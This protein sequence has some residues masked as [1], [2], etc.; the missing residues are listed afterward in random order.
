MRKPLNS[1]LDAPVQSFVEFV[2]FGGSQPGDR[3]TV[4][5]TDKI[6]DSITGYDFARSDYRTFR[7]QLAAEI[8]TLNSEKAELNER[9]VNEFIRRY[10]DI[11]SKEELMEVVD[12]IATKMFRYFAI[13]GTHI[14]W[15]SPTP[16]MESE[17]T[18]GLTNMIFRRADCKEVRVQFRDSGN[19]T[20][21]VFDELGK[22]CETKENLTTEDLAAFLSGKTNAQN[23]VVDQS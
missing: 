16:E 7:T 20:L 15:L 2:Y 6:G 9:G 14:H 13:R 8:V 11:L 4:F 1:L 23:K 12:S 18:F 17:S 19:A 22:L 21:R 3:R 5:V 10:L